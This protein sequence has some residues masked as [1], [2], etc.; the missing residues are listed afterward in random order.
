MLR[1]WNSPGLV[2][3]DR[4]AWARGRSQ[5]REGVGDALR[6][7]HLRTKEVEASNINRSKIRVEP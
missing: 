3:W 2:Q 5:A 7:P 4:H 6:R 1:S